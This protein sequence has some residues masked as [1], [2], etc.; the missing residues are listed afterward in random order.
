MP[1]LDALFIIVR[2]GNTF[3]TGE[4]ARRIGARTDLGLT[5][6]GVEQAEA[7]GAHF[8]AVN[9]RF[10][11]IIV[12]PLRRT[13]QTADAIIAAQSDPAVPEVADFLR[14]IDHGPDENQ[15]EEAV[16]ARIGA[17]ALTAW[18][19]E[20]IPPPD[21]SVEEDARIAAWRDL[22]ASAVPGQLPT[23]LVTSNGAAR[24]ALVAAKVSHVQ[25]LKLAT[26]SYGVIRIAADGA[27]DVP[28]WGERP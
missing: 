4:P 2:H 1:E 11:R 22:F 5:S 18:D 15:T 3:E 21:W 20:A 8:A 17:D 9:M 27:C 19:G 7:L 13:R 25:S 6:R 14:E 23:L 12:S 26:G 16:L 10:G 28:V 24:F